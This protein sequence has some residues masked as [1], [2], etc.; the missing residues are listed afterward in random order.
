MKPPIESQPLSP[1]EWGVVVVSVALPF[2]IKFTM[3]G[4]RAKRPEVFQA[5]LRKLLA[6]SV[7]AFP[8]LVILLVWKL[9]LYF[10]DLRQ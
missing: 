8:V 5:V 2:I 10:V 9:V 1:F 4:L 7:W 6:V 3:D